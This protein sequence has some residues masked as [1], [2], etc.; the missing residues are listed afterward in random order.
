[1]PRTPASWFSPIGGAGCSES[2]NNGAP[3]STRASS[4]N[5]PTPFTRFNSDHRIQN[6]RSGSNTGGHGDQRRLQSWAVLLN[7]LLNFHPCSGCHPA[8]SR[9]EANVQK[10]LIFQ[11]FYHSPVNQRPPGS[12]PKNEFSVLC[13]TN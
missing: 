5:A 11:W 1:M 9:F 7:K 2:T 6:V 12:T 3:T 13:S 8:S 10:A 4:P